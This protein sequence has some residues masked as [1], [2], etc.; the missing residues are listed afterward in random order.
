MTNNFGTKVKVCSWILVTAWIIA[1]IKPTTKAAIKM[2]LDSFNTR[3]TPSRINEVTV[4]KLITPPK[5]FLEFYFYRIELKSCWVKSPQPS[6]NTNKINLKGI[7][8]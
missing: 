4:P 2:G 6:I 3:N 1:T 5:L 7:E 8:I